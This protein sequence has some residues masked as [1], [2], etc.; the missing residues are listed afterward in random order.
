LKQKRS[1]AEARPR[2][3]PRA[4][5]META[6]KE[7]TD[8]FWRGGYS[9][10]SFDE[11]STATGVNPPSLYAAFGNKRALYLKSLAY[12]WDV[13]LGATRK[14]LAKDRPLAE[15]LMLAYEAALSIYFSGRHA[16]G[17]FVIGTAIAEAVEDAAI[18]KSIAEG[19]G[20]IDVD[21]E[22][23]FRLAI[24]KGELKQDAD[25]LALAIVAS[26][27]MHSIAVRARA[28]A[29]RAELLEIARQAVNVICRHGTAEV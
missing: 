6:L 10:T 22:A 1:K 20:K 9:G 3:R 19:L 17:C 16:R 29:R 13:S 24:D 27:T 4:Y 14:A 26:A 7:A 23:R 21:F 8:T 2:G 18:R 15:S 12:Y 5:D 11:I 28:G 25:P